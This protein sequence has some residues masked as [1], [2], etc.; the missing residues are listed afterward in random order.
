MKQVNTDEN[1]GYME[2]MMLIIACRSQSGE[3]KGVKKTLGWVLFDFMLNEYIDTKYG[4]GV[5]YEH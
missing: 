1:M 2:E 3:L 5:C 4:G